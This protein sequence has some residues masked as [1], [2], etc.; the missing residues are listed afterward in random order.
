MHRRKFMK[1][2]STLGTV[3]PA[4]ALTPAAFSQTNA[5]YSGKVLINVYAG[6]G[7]D[8][9]S[10]VDPREKDNSLNSYAGVM[11]AGVAGNI[12][13]APIANNKSFFEKYHKQ[14]LVINGIH[15]ESNDH[16]IGL[17][18]HHTGKLASGFPNIAELFASHYGTGLPMPWLNGI[19][20]NLSEGLSSGLLPPTGIPS[21]NT[22]RSMA[23]PNSASATQHWMKQADIGRLQQARSE[24]MQALKD[25]QG[26]PRTQNV[27]DQFVS[28][29]QSRS[30]LARLAQLMPASFDSQTSAH[31]A[32][33]CAAAGF[34][35]AVQIGTSGFDTH[36]DHD[37][38]MASQLPKLTDLVD[39]IWQKSAALNISDR[40]F[41]RIYSEFG[42]TPLN[43]NNGKDHLSVGSQVL[44]EANPTWG[45][46]VFGA[47]G[48]RHESQKIARNGTVDAVKGVVIKPR[49]MHVALRQYLKFTTTDPRFDLGVP[50]N[51]SFDFFDPT[52]MTGYPNL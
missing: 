29:S 7:L 41:L 4:W 14:C 18:A 16:G 5:P 3:I 11:A 33:I 10:W 26:L 42:R 24:R 32:L 23:E 20:I 27:V 37:V 38:I 19:G 52:A 45:N 25:A 48:P 40:I 1:M 28:A 22:L 21:A 36:K 47:S 17:R 49:H 31:I 34:T 30:A 6:G 44:M 50:S 12:R 2:A 35:T 43:S 51:E 46:R 15:S 39:Y 13:Y 9:S 8:Q